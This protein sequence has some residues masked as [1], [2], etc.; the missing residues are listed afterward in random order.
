MNTRNLSERFQ[1]LFGRTPRIYRAPGRVN[2][3]GEHTDYNEGFVMPMAIDLSAWVAIAPRE[4]RRIRVHSENFAEAIEFELS[5]P[6]VRGRGHWSDYARG[7]ALTIERAGHHLS[8]VDL[9]LMS[10]VP[11]GSGLSS[12]AAIEVATGLALL[13]TGERSSLA[14][15]LQAESASLNSKAQ[16]GTPNPASTG[17][18]RLELARLCQQAENDFVGMRCGIMD[19][20]SS[21]F[22]QKGQALLL[23]CRSLEYKSV[24]LPVAA[25]VVVCNTMVKHELAASAY[26]ARRAACEA[27]V[28][29]LKRSLP[30][31]GS[32]RDV[33]ITELELHQR[34][35]S[36]EVYRRCRHVISENVRV[37]D[38][39]GALESE[40]LKRFGDLMSASHRSLRDD[41]E[42]SCGELD[43][44]AELAMS[45][46]GVYGARMM[47]GGFGG[48][49]VNLVKTENVDSFAASIGQGYEQATGRKPEIYICAAAQGAERVE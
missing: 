48:C 36:D 6:A 43:L 41:Y 33:S 46:E 28:Q 42:V 38:A 45:A 14:L 9:L 44:M 15:R 16:G 40:D 27:G 32:L 24:R 31:I 47:G 17:I 1:S 13:E 19:Q 20:F 21:C 23:D 7:V 37:L 18:D 34:E 12:S 11:I 2:L 10:E 22:G 29:V 8:G 25:R 4:D 3:I 30:Q 39:A 26:N 35:M 49:T 5:D